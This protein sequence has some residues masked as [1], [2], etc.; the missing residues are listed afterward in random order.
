[1]SIAQLN[2]KY[3]YFLIYLTS[4]VVLKKERCHAFLFYILIRILLQSPQKSNAYSKIRQET[5][6]SLTILNSQSFLR[7]FFLIYFFLSKNLGVR[8]PTGWDPPE[9]A[10]PRCARYAAKPPRGQGAPTPGRGCLPPC[11][12]VC[13]SAM[14]CHYHARASPSFRGWS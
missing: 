6:H 1:M 10:A 5:W 7:S 13:C 14:C 8:H 3:F 4:L 2:D 11:A 12:R 9:Q